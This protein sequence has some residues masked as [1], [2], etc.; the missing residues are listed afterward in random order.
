VAGPEPAGEARH[1]LDYEHYIE[2]QVRG[3][4]EAVLAC[5]GSSWEQVWSGQSDL[6]GRAGD[7]PGPSEG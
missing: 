1:P 6:F 5:M 3:I 7:E 2:K 4:A